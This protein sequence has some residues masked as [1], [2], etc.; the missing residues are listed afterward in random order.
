VPEV[1]TPATGW[2]LVRT[3]PPGAT[4]TLDGIGRGQTPLSLRDVSFGT[5]RL[6]VSHAGFGTVQREVTVNEEDTVVPVG[7][8]LTP[9]SRSSVAAGDTAQTGSLAVRSRPPGAQ[10]TVN[11]T[12]AGVT[13]LVVALSIGRYQVR[14]QGDGY[15]PWMT[16]VEITAFE[17]AQVSAS[18]ERPTR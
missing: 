5:H 4:V 6:E 2:L 13:P 1:V 18:L 11:E 17:R 8:R 16:S 9:A 14:I 15:Q 10:V 3:D 12:S 7:V